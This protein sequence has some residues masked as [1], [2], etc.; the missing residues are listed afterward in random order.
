MK[1]IIAIVMALVVCFS[2]ISTAFAAEVADATIDKNKTCSLTINKYA[3]EVKETNAIEGVEFTVLNVAD[4]VTFKDSTAVQ[5]LYG[6]DKNVSAELLNAINL[7]NGK[8][9]FVQADKIDS[10]KY[11]YQQSVISKAMADALSNNEIKVKNALESYVSKSNNAQRMP[12]TDSKGQSVK[13]GLNVGLYLVA[14]TKAPENVIDTTNPFFVSLPM[15]VNGDTWNYD[16]VVYP[17][18]ETGNP[19]LDKEVRES[20]SSTGKTSQYSQYATGSAGDVME[21][22]I[23]STLPVVKSNATFLTEYRFV[24]TLSEG[25]SYNK[26]D[27]VFEIY[28]DAACAE[29]VVDWTENKNLFTV[30]YDNN[31]MTIDITKSGLAEINSKYS[32]H[33]ILIKYSAKVNS[34]ESLILGE[35]GNPNTVELTWKRTSENYYD[36]LEDDAI[37]YS[38]GIDITK[39]FS[40]KSDDEAYESGLYDKVEF[41]VFNA[42]DKVW[43]IAENIDGIYYVTGFAADAS[44]ATVFTPVKASDGVGKIKVFGVEDD[45]YTIY[46]TKTAE[47][48]TL[49][50]D[51]IDVSIVFKN[52]QASSTV[53]GKTVE[54]NANNQSKNAVVTLNVINN[55]VP[56]LPLTGDTGM[57]MLVAVG[58]VI[59][60]GAVIAVIK[61]NRKKNCD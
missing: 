22:K 13:T 36:T 17:K 59:M 54:M 29:K 14:E 2:T 32:E 10:N 31:T 41:K 61:I 16:V 1:K 57:V 51:D 42:T 38:F 30:T 52:Q 8:D 12:L 6:F 37:V 21:Y 23:E 24:D 35:N 58:V 33:T 9:R 55:K 34:D 47:G 20:Q 60:A 15:T 46:E 11:F 45:S 48:Y 19:T 49:L 4:I 39:H 50:E 56:D 28:S 40:D 25:I 44:K 18:N 53:A 3:Y 5:L 27:I 43:L 26:N 7:A